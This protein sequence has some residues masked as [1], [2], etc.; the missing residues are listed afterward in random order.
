MITDIIS[1]YN[2]PALRL[3]FKINEIDS[4]VHLSDSRLQSNPAIVLKWQHFMS[5]G[6]TLAAATWTIIV[7]DPVMIEL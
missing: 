3:W 7:R 5:L 4:L 1:F 6:L 2:D